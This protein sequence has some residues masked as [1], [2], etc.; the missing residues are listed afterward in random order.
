MLEEI[1]MYLLL[2]NVLKFLIA[3]DFINAY[4]AYIGT[5]DLII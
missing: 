1:R 2:L 4:Y 3:R 5:V